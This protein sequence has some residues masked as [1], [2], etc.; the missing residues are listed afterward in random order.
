[1]CHLA[2]VWY[3]TNIAFRIDFVI[4]SPLIRFHVEVVELNKDFME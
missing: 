3:V 1:M 4:Y 2:V